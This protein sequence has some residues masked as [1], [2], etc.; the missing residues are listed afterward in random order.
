MDARGG[1]RCFRN[2][3]QIYFGDV[4]EAEDGTCERQGLGLQIVTAVTVLGDTVVWG[5]Y[6]GSWKRDKMTG[7]G[8]YRWSDG[9]VYEG[10]FV[11]GRPHGHGKFTWPEGSSYDGMWA[12]GEMTGQGS[13]YN[14]FDGIT[15]MGVFHRNSV[16]MH[17]GSCVDLR[18]RREQ[19]RIERLR[20]G[21][22]G[23]GPEATIPV[24]RCGP[25]EVSAR[26]SAVLRE[27]PYLVPL[28]LATSMVPREVPGHSGSHSA[29]PLWCLQQGDCGLSGSTTV[30]LAFAA[31]EKRRRH[32][33]HEIFRSAIREA[34]LTY[35]PFALVFGDGSDGGNPQVEESLP[36]SHSL[37]EFFDA[38]SLPQDLFDLRHFQGSGGPDNFLPPD[39]RGFKCPS[40]AQELPPMSAPATV[41]LLHFVLV[42][43]R[44]LGRDPTDDE[45]RSHL[46][47][48]FAEHV[49]LHRVAAIV[50]APDK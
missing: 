37:N 19:H 1:R 21:Y 40:L 26:V 45:V 48:R 29:A 44:R 32:D 43:L 5:R 18:Q 50:V 31:A 12:E 28:V 49:P 35:R 25:S 39:K 7:S 27:P 10:F 33:V 2:A 38:M 22:S 23:P 8:T 15:R 34:L 13:F 20:I 11:D 46:T 16:R 6:K 47:R 4:V 17:D 9:S 42:S 41:H 36:P 24:L 14:A 30:H 3:G